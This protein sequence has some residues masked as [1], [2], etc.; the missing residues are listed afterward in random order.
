MKIFELNEETTGKL[1]D[2]K[3]GA[4]A[5]VDMGDG[6]KTVIDLKKNPSALVKSPDGKIMMNKAGITSGG[7]QTAAPDP[8]SMMKPGEPVFVT[9]KTMEDDDPKFKTIKGPHGR[10]D[11]D[12]SKKGITKVTRRGFRTDEP[13]RD[14][15]VGRG[16]PVGT[17][18]YTPGVGVPQ[19]S[20]FSDVHSD[21]MARRKRPQLDYDDD[22]I[23]ETDTDRRK[24]LGLG[25]AGAVASL[26]AGAGLGHMFVS[27]DLNK[28]RQELDSKK[29]AGDFFIDRAEDSLEAG[30][31]KAACKYFVKA[32]MTYSEAGLTDYAS[33]VKALIDVCRARGF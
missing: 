27:H 31:P 28:K 24:F 2:I 18:G 23:Q 15:Q 26:G 29:R 5:T 22:E 21:Y 30:D 17:T 9:D 32:Y 11:V 6:T 4:E 3:P 1:M 12:R 14:K 25:A 10:L 20:S 7:V 33:G 8:A 13:E 16:R 19:R